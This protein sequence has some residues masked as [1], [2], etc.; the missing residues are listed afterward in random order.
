[1]VQFKTPYESHD[2]SKKTLE[3]LYGYDAFLDSLEVV[4][5]L[6]C[7]M[8]LDTEWWATLET[9]DDPPEPRNYTVYAIDRN[10]ERIDSKVKSLPNI[11]VF[12]DNIDG[13]HFQLPKSADLIWCHDTF[14]YITDP[15]NTLKSW[16]KAMNVNGMLLLIFPQAQHYAYNRLQVHS[17]NNVYYNHNIVNLMY[18]LAVNG[19]DC[20]DAYFLKEENS[21]WLHAA[22]YKS[23]IEPMDPSTTNWYHLAE[24]NLLNESVVECITKYGYLKQEEIITS[25]LDKDFYF[26]K[27]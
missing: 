19:F 23:D 18:M 7:G 13:P 3:I 24:K 21:P 20:N 27:E 14:Q 22:V 2:H 4:A 5:D 15:I 17:Y 26:P 6:G 12:D 11:H 1:M 16:N 25:W 8:G 9:R 10:I